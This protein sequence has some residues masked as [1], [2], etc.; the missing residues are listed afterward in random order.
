[1]SDGD[2]PPFRRAFADDPTLCRRVF[3]LLDLAFGEDLSGQERAARRLGM[4]WED[5]STPF[6]RFEG[7]ELVAHVGVLALPLM[8]NGRPLR[9]GGIHAVATHPGRRRRGLYRS[10]MEEALAW[11]DARF[12]ALELCTVQPE[13]YEPFGFR[14]LPEQRFVGPGPRA[15][16]RDGLRALDYRAPGDV[17][18]LHRLLVQ[19]TPVSQRLGVAGGADVLLF[20]EARRPLHHAPDLDAVLSLELE[21]G[22]LRLYDV[23]AREIPPLAEILARIPAAPERVEVY[24]APDRLA[25]PALR[26]EPC[27]LNGDERFM[28]RGP[29]P[30]PDGPAMLPRTGRH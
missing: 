4:R 24:F 13:L 28:V 17:A 27:V 6:C 5:V 29:F 2:G 11:C 3:A 16:G 21:P 12:D 30:E 8:V 20:D 10:V 9:A 26:A 14:V 19:R 15:P 18:L 22:V 23:V 25:A 7:G 1:M